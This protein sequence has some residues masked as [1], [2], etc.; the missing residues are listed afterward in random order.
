MTLTLPA[1]VVL[2]SGSLTQSL[3]TIAAGS[4]RLR[5]LRAGHDIGGRQDGEHLDIEQ[6]LR[7]DLTGG[8]SFMVTPDPQDLVDPYTD[9]A[10][11]PADLPG[12]R[13]RE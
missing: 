12:R 7:A 5:L 3:G 1:G 4:Y 9:S 6:F 13:D 11:R 2:G 10:D 8:G